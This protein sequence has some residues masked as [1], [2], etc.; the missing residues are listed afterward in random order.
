LVDRKLLPPPL[1]PPQGLAPQ[2][3]ETPNQVKAQVAPVDH[4]GFNH[5]QGG[6]FDRLL[7][8]LENIGFGD[9]RNRSEPGTGVV[10]L[11][12]KSIRPCLYKFLA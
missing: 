9:P 6:V 3:I 12:K 4:F 10:M 11:P 1:D 2:E 8:E 7:M 5:A